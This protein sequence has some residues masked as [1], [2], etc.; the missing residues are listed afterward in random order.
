VQVTHFDNRSD[1]LEYG[2]LFNWGTRFNIVS[3]EYTTG[4]WAFAA[5]NGW[6][7]TFL[8]VEHAGRFTDDIQAGYALASRR[9]PRSRATVRVDSFSVDEERENA[10]TFAWF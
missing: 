6:G 2:E 10:V 1:G 3:A 9:F 4:D 8:I 5:E 7:P